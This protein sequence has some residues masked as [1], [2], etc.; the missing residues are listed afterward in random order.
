M[1]DERE[2]KSTMYA[3]SEDGSIMLVLYVDKKKNVKEN[4]VLLTRMQDDVRVTKDER[5]KPDSLVLYDHTKGGVDVVDLVSTHNVTRIKH[6][7]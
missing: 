6:K 7:R 3:F 5:C 1:L 2:P 4:I